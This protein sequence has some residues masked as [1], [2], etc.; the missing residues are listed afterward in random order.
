MPVLPIVKGVVELD[1]EEDDRDEDELLEDSELLEDDLLELLELELDEQ[2]F[3]SNSI[4]VIE[5][6]LVESTAANKSISLKASSLNII[7]IIC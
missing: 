3:N 4:L 1:E 7:G 2:T 6:E 5:N